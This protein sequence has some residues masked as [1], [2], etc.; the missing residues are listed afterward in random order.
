MSSPCNFVQ[1]CHWVHPPQQQSVHHPLPHVRM[2]KQTPITCLREQ[3]QNG[4]ACMA[5]NH[6]Q[7][8]LTRVC[9]QD[10]PNECLGAHDI[11]RC[12]AKETRRIVCAYS[13]GMACMVAAAA[14]AACG[15]VSPP[16]GWVCACVSEHSPT[17]GCACAGPQHTISMQQT[18]NDTMELT[19]APHTATGTQHKL[20]VWAPLTA[21]AGEEESAS[22]ASPPPP[23]KTHAAHLHA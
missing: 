13:S 9:G 11:Q 4:D 14:L 12:H 21:A 18:V 8:D 15:Y 16:G 3:R 20:A 5:A 17:C 23:K 2:C 7:A 19:H 10:L 1:I 6:G 22:S